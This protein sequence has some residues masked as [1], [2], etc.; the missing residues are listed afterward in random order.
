MAK[1]IMTQ[2]LPAS[3]KSTWAKEEVRISNGK[4]KRVNK[5][6][7]RNMVD[8]GKW[9]KEKEKEILNIRDTLIR[10]WLSNG[11][12]VIVDDT[13]LHNKH[14]SQLKEIVNEL[15]SNIKHLKG[16]KYIDFEINDSFIDV[17]LMECIERDAKRGEKSVG[18]KVIT[19]MYFDYIFNKHKWT[20]EKT[21][22]IL[23]K[24]LSTAIIVDLDGT[25]AIHDKRDPFDPT[26]ISTDMFNYNLWY[27]IEPLKDRII[28]LSGREG[29]KF[30]RD[31][32]IKWIEKYTG[33]E[34]ITLYMRN[35]GDNRKDSIVKEEI[36]KT[37]VKPYYNV[38]A[39]YDDRD[40]VVDMWRSLGLFTCQVN[41]GGF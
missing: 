37:C 5:D 39:V 31:E 26:Y 1:L 30:C 16:N 14:V 15:N 18:K 12:N 11:Y 35:E 3:G 17:P 10:S 21:Y 24:S 25:L 28:F 27:L 29:N 41:Y 6:D 4:T 22:E 36:F 19:K 7:L 23:K 9:S 2:G 38:I 8:A 34:D 32:T 40:Q 20:D 13:N 33:L